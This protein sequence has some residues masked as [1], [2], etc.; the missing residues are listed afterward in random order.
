MAFAP[1]LQRID[2]GAQ[3]LADLR[4]A[5]LPPRRHLGINFSNDEPVVL[6]RAELLGQHALGDAGHPA[7]QLAEAL[8]SLLQVIE[9]DAF[10][11]AVDEVECRLDR[12]AWPVREI[13]P[14]HA[15]FPDVFSGG[16]F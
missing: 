12:A 5:V 4:Q 1:G 8:R 6:E 9:N 2:D 16:L 11:L 3:A 10:P 15:S 13:L 14:F 7:P